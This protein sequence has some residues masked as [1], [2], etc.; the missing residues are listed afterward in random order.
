[1]RR[2]LLYPDSVRDLRSLEARYEKATGLPCDLVSERESA[3]L[4]R[5]ARQ[6]VKLSHCL[7]PD[8]WG[9]LKHARTEMYTGFLDAI[10]T[11]R[12]ASYNP[13][14]TLR[15]VG[16]A[17]VR[18]LAE[19][20][21]QILECTE[22]RIPNKIVERICGA[23]K[24]A[25]FPHLFASTFAASMIQFADG[26]PGDVTPWVRNL[27]IVAAIDRSEALRFLGMR[28]YVIA[29]IPLTRTPVGAIRGAHLDEDPEEI[30]RELLASTVRLIY[31]CHAEDR[32][33]SLRREGPHSASSLHRPPPDFRF[34]LQET[35]PERSYEQDRFE[36]DRSPE[37][38]MVLGM[39]SRVIPGMVLGM[40]SR[41]IPGT[42]SQVIPGHRPMWS[43]RSR[44]G[45]RPFP[46]MPATGMA[47]APRVLRD[48]RPPHS[49]PHARRP[50][51]DRRFDRDDEPRAT[52]GIVGSLESGI[53]PGHES[54]EDSAT[55]ESDQGLDAIIGIATSH[56]T[57]DGTV[58][59]V[60][61]TPSDRD[62]VHPYPH[63]AVLTA[64]RTSRDDDDGDDGDDDESERMET[65]YEASTPSTSPASPT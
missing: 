1:M 19:A 24:T 60:M 30:R 51:R 62:Q 61:Y 11:T 47:D 16:H 44:V 6:R 43:E 5:N 22:N 50:R 59:T 8:V 10:M 4:V 41:V 42:V 64:L 56:A 12:T 57:R 49:V 18:E 2:D 33:E 23:V 31:V 28:K 63:E 9:K 27:V 29:N 15:R 55:V 25:H 17:N 45:M 48:R 53:E 34:F 20:R 13:D 32:A 39:G 36:Y 26:V 52:S 40:G 21:S 38:E 54:G 35:I 14:G 7:R 65:D 3:R 37:S 46:V 58:S